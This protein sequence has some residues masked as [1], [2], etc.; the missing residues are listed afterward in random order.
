LERLLIFSESESLGKSLAERTAFILSDNGDA[1]AKLSE[2]IKRFYD[3]RSGIVHGSRKKRRLLSPRLQ[4][5]TDRI[6]LLLCLKLA[7]NSTL[8]NS[9]EALRIWSESQKWGSATA[10]PAEGF[11][12]RAFAS[13]LKMLE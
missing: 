7:A 5:S 2:S 13:T 10:R 9:V 3:A 1:R 4:E 8:W 6:V 12:K 11:S